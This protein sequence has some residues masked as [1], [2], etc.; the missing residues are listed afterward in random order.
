[1]VVTYSSADA[2]AQLDEFKPEIVL[3][4]IGLP[5][6]DGYEIARRI[7]SSAEHRHMRLIALTGYGQADDRQR[8]KESGFDDHLVKPVEFFALQR[9]LAAKVSSSME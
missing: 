8:A 5:E 4:D 2:L 1:V 6:I 7:K 3:L 9:V